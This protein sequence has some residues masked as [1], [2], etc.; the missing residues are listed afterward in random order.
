M[1]NGNWLIV[2]VRFVLAGC[3][4]WLEKHTWDPEFFNKLCIFTMWLWSAC[5]ATNLALGPC[6]YQNFVERCMWLSTLSMMLIYFPCFSSLCGRV[7]MFTVPYFLLL[8]VTAEAIVCMLAFAAAILAGMLPET[9][10]MPL[11]QTLREGEDIP[12]TLLPGGLR[13]LSRRLQN[14]ISNSYTRETLSGDENAIATSSRFDTNNSVNGVN[15]TSWSSVSA[16][17]SDTYC[18]PGF[19]GGNSD[20]NVRNENFQFMNHSDLGIGGLRSLSDDSPSVEM[21]VPSPS[22]NRVLSRSA[23]LVPAEL[24][25]SEV[26]DNHSAG[27]FEI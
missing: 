21:V 11:P 10:N 9:N 25:D 3:R 4:F 19:N 17:N 12:L 22:A 23:S 2:I 13:G 15:P 5:F 18:L 1:S 27:H 16:V 26:T 7:G 14:L 8:G 20:G 6:V 24:S